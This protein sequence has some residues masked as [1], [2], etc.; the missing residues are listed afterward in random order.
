MASRTTQGGVTV[1]VE[2]ESRHGLTLSTAV[3]Y[4]DLVECIFL[5]TAVNE[6]LTTVRSRD[7]ITRSGL[8]RVPGELI[9]ECDRSARGVEEA[10]VRVGAGIAHAILGERSLTVRVAARNASDAAAIHELVREAVPEVVGED[11]E[12]PVRFWWWQPP[13]GPRELARMLP[14][15]SWSDVEHNYPGASRTR[16]A[17]LADWRDAPPAG[18]R[19]ILWHGEPGTGKTSAIRALASEWRSWAGF[20]FV[21]D[22]EEFLA[23]PSYLL[24]TISENHRLAS[25]ASR[26]QWRI[27]VLEDAGEY[28][29]PDAKQTRGQALSRLLNVCDGVLGQAMNA[30]I[31][32]TT[33]EPLRSLHPALSRPGRCV[34]QVGFER[35]D[36]T[37]IEEWARR[38]GCKVPERATATVA[39]LYAG[40]TGGFEVPEPRRFGFGGGG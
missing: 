40:A 17:A 36:R 39:D 16:L 20:H 24:S 13:H 31:L 19:L 33:N 6:S 2:A 32:V 28:L 34:A 27:V 5:Q 22:P 4:S 37:S 21:T 14:A 26:K 10:L 35:F 30:L 7:W 38:E 9:G 12:I 8:D 1:S 23:N 29:A 3:A 11:P 18:G 15:C 25:A